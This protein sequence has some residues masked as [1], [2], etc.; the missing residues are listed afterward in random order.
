MAESELQ[1]GAQ[2]ERDAF[3]RHLK[4]EIANL[5]AHPWEGS[6]IEGATLRRELD[7]VDSRT[8]RYNRVAGG[9]SSRRKTQGKG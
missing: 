8:E 7:W 4:R 3:R 6:L 5:N 9:L 1:V 2:K